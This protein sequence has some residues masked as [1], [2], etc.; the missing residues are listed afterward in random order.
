MKTYLVK[1]DTNYD[2]MVHVVNADNEED[3]IRMAKSHAKEGESGAWDG[4]EAVEIDT[5]TCGV[6]EWA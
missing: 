1:S 6:V 3:A 5:K 4:C 2:L